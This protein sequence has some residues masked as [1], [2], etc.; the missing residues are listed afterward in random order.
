[1]GPIK[2]TLIDLIHERGPEKTICPSEVAR[3]C[4]EKNWRTLMP[5][6]RRATQELAEEEK[7]EVTQS[8]ESVNALQASGPIRIG[9]SQ[10]EEDE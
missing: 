2:S 9:L 5:D 1:M 8:G 7:V 3:A 10:S 6:V 4:N